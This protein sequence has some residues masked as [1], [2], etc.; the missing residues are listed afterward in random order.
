MYYNRPFKIWKPVRLTNLVLK[1]I[2]EYY[3]IYIYSSSLHQDL[4]QKLSRC[5]IKYIPINILRNILT[6]EDSVILIEEIVKNRHFE[7]SDTGIETYE[8]I[9][10][11]QFPQEYQDGCVIIQDDLNEKKKNDPRLQAMFK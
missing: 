6:E 8:S 2:N 9:E 4:Y 10:Q 1:I 3:K 5:F 11:L 7:K